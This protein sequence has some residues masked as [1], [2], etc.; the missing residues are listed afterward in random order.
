MIIKLSEINISSYIFPPNIQD[1]LRNESI[2]YSL[3]GDTLLDRIGGAHKKVITLHFGLC[4]GD[5]WESVKKVLCQPSFPVS[6][7]TETDINLQDV[8]FRCSS[9]I[10]T[11]IKYVDDNEYYIA[12]AEV[13][14]EEL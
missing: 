11:P 2:S 3:S 14:I 1:V 9:N 5:V 8:P 7:E 6:I 10:P 4:P 13:V 12:D